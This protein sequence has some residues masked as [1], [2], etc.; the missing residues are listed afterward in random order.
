MSWRERLFPID[1]ASPPWREAWRQAYASMWPQLWLT[2][3]LVIFVVAASM[4]GWL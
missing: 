3:A 2:G 1:P 4:L